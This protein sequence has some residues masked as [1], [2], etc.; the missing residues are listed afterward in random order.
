[1]DAPPPD[2]HNQTRPEG[3]VCDRRYICNLLEPVV[4]WVSVEVKQSLFRQPYQCLTVNSLNTG[5][6]GPMIEPL[7]AAVANRVLPRNSFA[8]MGK[9]AC[10]SLPRD[11]FTPHP[12]PWK[13][14][15][16]AQDNECAECSHLATGPMAHCCVARHSLWCPSNYPF[17][18]V[19]R[20]RS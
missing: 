8:A 3:K 7:A 20:A 11:F 2:K 12:R 14:K 6:I 18:F 5:P 1:M 10:R 15:A 9:P 17:L 16:R 19:C 13:G 4:V